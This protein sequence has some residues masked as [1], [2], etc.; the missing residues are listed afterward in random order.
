MTDMKSNPPPT[1]TENQLVATR[2]QVIAELL[3]ADGVPADI[4]TAKAMVNLGIDMLQ[5]CGKVP[6]DMIASMLDEAATNVRN[7]VRHK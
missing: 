6:T 5:F 1:P 7:N 4:I 2:V 3:D